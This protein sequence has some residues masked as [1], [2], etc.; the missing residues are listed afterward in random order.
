MNN[1]TA[2]PSP[3]MLIAENRSAANQVK[4][5]LNRLDRYR[6]HTI[7][8]QH[9]IESA[10]NE[11]SP[12]VT[13]LDH[14]SL[15][16]HTVIKV[17]QLHAVDP[18]MPIIIL[19]SFAGQD[20]AVSMLKAGAHD[21]ILKDNIARL[22]RA[23]ITETSSA[24]MRRKKRKNQAALQHLALHDSLTGL[25]NRSEFERRVDRALSSA[26]HRGLTHCLM[27]L[28][29]DQFKVVNDT[30]GHMAGDALL[31]NL[32]A[33]LQKNVRERDTL[34]RLGGDEFG[35]LLE[36][37]P[38][39]RGE[40]I[41]EK[42]RQAIHNFKFS[43]GQQVFSVGLSI[44][45]TAVDQSIRSVNEVLGIADKACYSAKSQGRNIVYTCRNDNKELRSH[46]CEVSWLA[47]LNDALQNNH[48]ELYQH[49]V[50]SFT[51]TTHPPNQELLLRMKDRRGKLMSPASF[52]PSAERHNLM[53]AIDHWV[54]Q[55]AFEHIL[56][57]PPASATKTIFI[58]LS[59]KTL[60]SEKNHQLIRDYLKRLSSTQD[61]V[62]FDITETSA[63]A[64]LKN[65]LEF[66]ESIKSD[67][68]K[69][70][71]DDFGSGTGAFSYLQALPVDYI[72]INSH[73]IRN[74]MK[75]KMDYAIVDSINRLCHIAGIKTI[76][77]HVENSKIQHHLAKLGIDYGQGFS[78]E[79]P[80]P[81][82]QPLI[83]VS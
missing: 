5:I 28:D 58:N 24:N 70:A 79:K 6:I 80:K 56:T 13:L 2:D 15:H 9:N 10:L 76:A 29:L 75:N 17:Q 82:K 42:L 41:A 60:N 7:D 30:C 47:Q 40:D 78:I 20:M 23:I 39:E 54:I 51:N 55:H 38:L 64:D 66:I 77:E 1:S 45:I 46:Q 50:V 73:Y 8:R 26:Q 27:Y 43:W 74:M 16:E 36:N 61:N 3:L 71:L 11:F 59:G 35:I 32:S 49:S 68:C 52:L 12:A 34:A 44:G 25:I 57:S 48:F 81:L 83:E 53:P 31:R 62:C 19:S 14:D 22:P 69:I 4:H 33:I 37:C 72:K 65:T 63:V 21:Y 18:D 67:G